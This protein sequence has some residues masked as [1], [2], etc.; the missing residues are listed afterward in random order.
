MRRPPSSP[1]FQRAGAFVVPLRRRHGTFRRL[2]GIRFADQVAA[3]QMP[4][5]LLGGAGWRWRHGRPI[6]QGQLNSAQRAALEA[7]STWSELTMRRQARVIFRGG[8]IK[9]L[10]G[11]SKRRAMLSMEPCAPGQAEFVCPP[12]AACGLCGITAQCCTPPR[13]AMMVMTDCCTAPRSQI[14][15]FNQETS[16]VIEY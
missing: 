8:H 1:S 5:R 4:D 14:P 11:W 7:M 3:E 2:A 15:S 12:E 9:G 10:S 6:Q 13:V 16:R